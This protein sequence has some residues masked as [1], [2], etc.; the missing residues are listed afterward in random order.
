[1][2]LVTIDDATKEMGISGRELLR[3]VMDRRI[4][5]PIKFFAWTPDQFE[6]VRA[7]IQ[8]GFQRANLENDLRS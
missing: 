7:E 1:V 8:Q 5:R 3:L 6:R 2:Q 4:P